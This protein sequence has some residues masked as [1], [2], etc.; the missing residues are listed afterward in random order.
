MCCGGREGEV[1]GLLFAETSEDERRSD[2]TTWRGW[3]EDKDC[4]SLNKKQTIGLLI[5]S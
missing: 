1:G 5:E 2:D 4:A 3:L